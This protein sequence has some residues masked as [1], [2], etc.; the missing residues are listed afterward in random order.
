MGHFHDKPLEFKPGEKSAYCNSGYVLCGAIIEHMNPEGLSYGDF[1]AKY[2]FQPA[3]MTSSGLYG[4]EAY[5]HLP[6]AQGKR[7]DAATESLLEDNFAKASEAHAAGGL[8]STVEDMAKWNAALD[9]T[10]VLSPASIERMETPNKDGWGYGLAIKRGTS[11]I[12]GPFQAFALTFPN[13]P[14]E[15]IAQSCCATIT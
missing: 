8:Y 3:G 15:R 11:A 7:M 12:A 2:L 1:V 14:I 4:D 13:T 6:K 9:G 5:H 10:H